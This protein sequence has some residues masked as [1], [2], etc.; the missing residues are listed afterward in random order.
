M[1]LTT[2]EDHCLESFRRTGNCW[3]EVGRPVEHDG[4]IQFALAAVLHAGGLA[5][6]RGDDSGATLTVLPGRHVHG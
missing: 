2:L 4:W 3:P 1:T 6:D 5:R